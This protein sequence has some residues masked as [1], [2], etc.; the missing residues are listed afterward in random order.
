MRHVDLYIYHNTLIKHSRHSNLY[1]MCSY[2]NS[3]DQVVSFHQSVIQWAEQLSLLNSLLVEWLSNRNQL[4]IVHDFAVAAVV[5][6]QCK[7]MNFH[8][9]VDVHLNITISFI[10]T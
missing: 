3:M 5:D 6:V 4:M 1:L 7:M 2:C 9:F 8:W 10:K